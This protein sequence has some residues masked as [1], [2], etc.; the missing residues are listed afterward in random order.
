MTHQSGIPLAAGY[1]SK[2]VATMAVFLDK[3]APA[4]TAL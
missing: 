3:L 2:T 1:I 4:F